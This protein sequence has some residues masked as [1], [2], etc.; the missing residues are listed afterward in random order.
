MGRESEKRKSKSKFESFFSI[1]KKT[2]K[3]GRITCD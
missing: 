2:P 1:R 3:A